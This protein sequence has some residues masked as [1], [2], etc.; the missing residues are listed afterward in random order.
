MRDHRIFSK[1][2]LICKWSRNPNNIRHDHAYKP[3]HI[4]L[5][6]QFLYVERK[7][8]GERFHK[9]LWEQHV[10]CGVQ[11]NAYI[12]LKHKGKQVDWCYTCANSSLKSSQKHKSEKKSQKIATTT[13]YC[14]IWT[15]VYS[16]VFDKFHYYRLRLSMTQQLCLCLSSIRQKKYHR[17]VTYILCSWPL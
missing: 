7:R 6:Q 12:A 14:K 13:I 9:R 17:E 5:G 16:M 15:F 11:H 3:R 8:E 10:D 4:L 1:Y 2:S